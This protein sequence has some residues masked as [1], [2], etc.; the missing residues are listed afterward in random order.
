MCTHD[1]RCAPVA[2]PRTDSHGAASGGRA[3]PGLGAQWP[4]LLRPCAPTLAGLPPLVLERYQACQTVCFCGVFPELKRAW[5]SVD[6]S[7]FL[8]RFDRWCAPAPPYTVVDLCLH[9]VCKWQSRADLQARAK[10]RWRSSRAAESAVLPP[11]RRCH[12]RH[13][14][15][16]AALH[17]GPAAPRRS[18]VPRQS[19]L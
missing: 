17:A 18:L 9:M 5:A 11:W 15:K 7:L 4:S 3:E 1:I 2:K 10:R 14:V 8:W 16:A 13:P 12:R 6:N 19:R